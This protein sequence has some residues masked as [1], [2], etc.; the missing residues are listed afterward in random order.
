MKYLVTITD[1]IGE[2]HGEWVVTN[3]DAISDLLDRNADRFGVI[4]AGNVEE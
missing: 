3:P 2:V 4:P 1:N